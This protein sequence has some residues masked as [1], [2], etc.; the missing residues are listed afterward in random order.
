MTDFYII[1]YISIEW[2]S[3]LVTASKIA[4]GCR[5]SHSYAQ[6]VTLKQEMYFFVLA[7]VMLEKV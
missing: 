6:Y 1:K 2:E 5:S 3:F 4:N 7:L